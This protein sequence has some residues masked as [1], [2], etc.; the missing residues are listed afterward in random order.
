M[1][2]QWKEIDSTSFKYQIWHKNFEEFSWNTK[3]DT[4][5][6]VTLIGQYKIDEDGNEMLIEKFNCIND[7]HEKTGN[8]PRAYSGL[9]YSVCCA[10]HV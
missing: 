2:N 6:F 8:K 5:K 7:I 4:E 3:I 1:N 9:F 10:P